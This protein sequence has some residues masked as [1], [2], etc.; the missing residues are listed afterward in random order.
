MAIERTLVVVKPDGVERSLIGEIISRYERQGLKIKALKL[1]RADESLVKRH[2]PDGLAKII[3]EKSVKAGSKIENPEA[4]GKKI[5]E[6]LRKFISSENVIAMV[7][8]GENAIQ[9]VRDITGYTDPAA[10]EK[11]TIRGDLGADS[12]AKANVEMRP[13]KNLVHAS[14]TVEEAEKEIGLWFRKDEIY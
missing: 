8:E 11:G 10:A 4:H 6:Q 9:R 13:V 5:L 1:F 7:L 2:Y 14:G 12:I 3:G